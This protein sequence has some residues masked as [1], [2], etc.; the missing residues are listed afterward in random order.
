M[1]AI[2]VIRLALQISDRATMPL[3]ENMR[4]APLT[5]PTS[6]GG[7]H[8]LWILGHLTI[9]EGDVRYYLFGEENPV[10]H[11]RPL[12]GPGAEPRADAS[13]YPAFD[14]VLAKY[15]ELRAWNMALLEDI[16][17]EGLEQ[18]CKTWPAGAEE[19]FGTFGKVFLMA[20]IDQM[21]HRGQVADARR[22]AGRKPLFTPGE[23]SVKT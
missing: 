19:L 12:F 5:Q 8:P 4:D 2:D 14:D 9:N 1:K 18:P 20:A 10:E 16:G 15:R 7:N 22:V 21:N 6:R 13:C 17:D 3:I 11:W 23:D